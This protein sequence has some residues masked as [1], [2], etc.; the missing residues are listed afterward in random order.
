VIARRLLRR[1]IKK[2][3]SSANHRNELLFDDDDNDKGNAGQIN[4][5]E[6]EID[7]LNF[8]PSINPEDYS[9][10]E[11]STANDD[12]D[13]DDDNSTQISMYSNKKST[14][15]YSQ[16][17]YSYEGG[18]SNLDKIDIL[19]RSILRRSIKEYKPSNLLN[20][21]PSQ[22]SQDALLS[23]LISTYDHCSKIVNDVNQGRLALEV[24]KVFNILSYI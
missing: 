14:D 13:D 2:Q 23:S 12:D 15:V 19:D 3:I 4:I 22:L 24:L 6:D 18:K 5:R 21:V 20:V 16:N 10:S 8:K 7:D 11:L 17:S 1:K 9:I